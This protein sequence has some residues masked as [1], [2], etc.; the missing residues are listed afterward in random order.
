M[1]QFRDEL[2]DARPEALLGTRRRFLT[3][4]GAAA[5]LALS[6]R[7]PGTGN[8]YSN[9]RALGAYPFTLGVAS[10]DPLPDSVVLWTRL[11]PDA[12]DPFGGM[13]YRP[14]DV[15]WELAHDEAFTRIVQHGATVAHPE[16]AHSVHI[17]VQRARARP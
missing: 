16:F 7:L 10:G 17:D 8:A 2:A 3:L 12:L 9:A 1:Q 13:P 15:S 4:A 14:V 11:A 6:T 5:V